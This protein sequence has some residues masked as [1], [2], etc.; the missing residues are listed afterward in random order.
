MVRLDFAFRQ[1]LFTQRSGSASLANSQRLIRKS[2]VLVN[3]IVERQPKRQV[4]PGV[5]K[6][7][8]AATNEEIS[9]GDHAFYLMNKPRNTLCTTRGFG[10]RGVTVYDLLRDGVKGSGSAQGG[11]GGGDDSRGSTRDDVRAAGRLDRDTTGCL[12]FGTD[13]GLLS[14]LLHPT[15]RCWKTY[16][17]VLDLD[18]SELHPNAVDVFRAGLTLDDGTKC[19][20][21]FL[22]IVECGTAQTSR[23]SPKV[24]RV[25]LHEGFFH[26][27]KRMLAQV[28]GVVSELHRDS[29]GSLHL[30]RDT[31]NKPCLAPGEVRP[32]TQL[33]LASLVEML[34]PDPPSRVMPRCSHYAPS[35]VPTASTHFDGSECTK[36]KDGGSASAVQDSH[37]LPWFRGH[38]ARHGGRVK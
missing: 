33:E 11:G 5:E 38:S 10:P 30:P 6:I 21:A 3:G 14:L 19:A 32:L 22:E 15:S 35:P 18:R 17:A 1:F 8:L 24:V 37:L 25:S 27:V 12:L 31:N 13:H 2:K 36:H 29:F 20:P 28:G 4:I 7:T 16:T 26:Q 23:G 9:C 34:P